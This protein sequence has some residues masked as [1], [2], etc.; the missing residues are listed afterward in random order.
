MKLK[1]LTLWN[2]LFALSLLLA[3]CSGAAQSP[4]WPGLA[5]NG[6]LAYVAFNQQIHFISLSDGKPAGA[7]PAQPN[8]NTGL[9]FATPGIGPDVVVFGSEGPINSYSGILYGVDPTTGQQRWCLAFDQEGAQRQTCP[10]A[11]DATSAGFLGIAPP[12]DNRIIGGITV[13]EG[14]AYFGLASGRVYAV[15]AESGADQWSYKTEGAVWAAPMVAEDAVYV[16]SLDHSVYALDRTTGT[17]RWSTNLGAGIAGTPAL[18]DGTLFIGSF[19]NKL[20]A[21]DAATGQ[22]KWSALAN[23]WVWGGPVVQDGV[24]YFAD[25]AGT[26]FAID[27][28]TGTQKWAVT[29]GENGE[30][31]TASPALSKDA[32]YVGN[33]A[34]RIFALDLATGATQWKQELKGQ[35]LTTP[36]LAGD[37]VLI[38]PFSGDNLLV[39]FTA[40]GGA[41]KW[42]FAPSK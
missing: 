10:M 42:A 18:W 21:L 7:F 3:A 39:A 12:T 24:V 28:A 26:V 16:T 36:I 31:I 17:L 14:V 13:A 20:Y 27:A 19:G 1:S 30:A 6:N 5:A 41:Q 29:P 4:G 11:K 25:L 15:D 37:T 34:G 9:S 2:L 23:Y 33:K 40:D 22:E 8:N 32:L 35:L 38:T